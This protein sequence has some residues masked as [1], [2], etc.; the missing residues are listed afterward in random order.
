MLN[1]GNYIASLGNVC[2]W[3]ATH[4]EG[5]GVEIYPGLGGSELVYAATGR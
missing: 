5:L 2:R 4:A 1:H 3:L